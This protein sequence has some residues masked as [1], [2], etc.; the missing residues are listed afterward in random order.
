MT[1]RRHFLSALGAAGATAATGIGASVAHAHEPE[2]DDRTPRSDFFGRIFHLPPFAV[3]F[4]RIFHLPPF[5]E[6]TQA[7]KAALLGYRNG[8]A[9][10]ELRGIEFAFEQ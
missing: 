9:S 6:P 10:E 3:F 2:D 5:A 8:T 7:V 4:G 1:T